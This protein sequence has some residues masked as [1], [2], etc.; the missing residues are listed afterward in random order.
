MLVHP[1]GVCAP[2]H[3]VVF[4]RASAPECMHS[5]SIGKPVQSAVFCCPHTCR[6]LL[7]EESATLFLSIVSGLSPPPPSL[8]CNII[9]YQCDGCPSSLLRGGSWLACQDLPAM[10]AI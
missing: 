7:F 5:V 9:S 2:L 3:F 1:A 4:V 10:G 8:F 6:S